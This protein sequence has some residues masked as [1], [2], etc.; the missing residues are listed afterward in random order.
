M[1]DKDREKV[2]RTLLRHVEAGR[3]AVDKALAALK[4]LDPADFPPYMVPKLLE[5]GAAVT[6]SAL[7]ALRTLDA[8]E[9]PESDPWEA[10][11][12]SLEVEEDRAAR[13]R[14]GVELRD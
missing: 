3:M 9:R 10:I 12:R 6:E 11:A 2:R 4:G 13:Y 5:T 8:E 1:L 14:P 7:A